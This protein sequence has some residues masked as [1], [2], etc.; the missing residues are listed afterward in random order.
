MSD[1]E[2]KMLE[3]PTSTESTIV[4]DNTSSAEELI[5]TIIS[6]NSENV[7]IE[8]IP[9]SEGKYRIVITNKPDSDEKDSVDTVD[10]DDLEKTTPDSDSNFDKKI[11]KPDSTESTDS[12]E[13]TKELEPDPLEGKDYVIQ[14]DEKWCEIHSK[15]KSVKNK[16]K[17]AKSFAESKGIPFIALGADPKTAIEEFEKEKIKKESES[18]IVKQP[19]QSYM[20]LSP[21]DTDPKKYIEFPFLVYDLPLE[22]EDAPPVANDRY[23]I[24][25]DGMGGAGRTRVVV[26]GEVRKMAYL[27][28]RQIIQ[29]ADKYMDENYGRILSESLD[30]ISY[31]LGR[32]ILDGLE[33]FAEGNSIT[34]N[35]T[36][37]M[38]KFLPS[39]FVSIVYKEQED[40]ID[41]IVFWAGDSRA[42]YISPED[43]LHPLS[44]DDAAVDYDD[45]GSIYSQSEISNVPCLDVPFHINYRRYLLKKPCALFVC[46]DG[47]SQYA[48]SP[49]D[50]EAMFIPTS[51]DFD[52]CE[53]IYNFAFT[54][55]HD[56]RTF[57]GKVYGVSNFVEFSELMRDRGESVLK[58]TRDI[59]EC[60]KEYAEKSR[61]Y[62]DL[63]KQPSTPENKPL[64]KQAYK[65]YGEMDAIFKKM[66]NDYWSEYKP[67]YESIKP[68]AEGA[69][70][71][72][73]CND[74]DKSIEDSNETSK[75]D[76]VSMTV[77][78]SSTEEG[79][80]SPSPI[81]VKTPEEAERDPPIDYDHKESFVEPPTDQKEYDLWIKTQYNSL[82]TSTSVL[83]VQEFQRIL[84]WRMHP[85]AFSC[86]EKYELFYDS[87]GMAAY[88][89]VVKKAY[90][91]DAERRKILST[92][93]E[94]FFYGVLSIPRVY[95]EDGYL[96]L[97]YN[98]LALG[99]YS[100]TR[101]V[102]FKTFFQIL[103][104]V[105]SYIERLH[106]YG[107]VHGG[108]SKGIEIVNIKGSWRPII[109]D[110]LFIHRLSDRPS[111]IPDIILDQGF[112][113]DIYCLGHWFKRINENQYVTR[114]IDS[115]D[116]LISDMISPDL[117]KRPDISAVL[118]RLNEL[119]KSL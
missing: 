13:D 2:E 70:P 15:G 84:G 106:N 46:S 101:P 69:S 43:G 86:N 115:L 29:S 16:T 27:A 37:K 63:N 73:S 93:N 114:R 89:M 116:P 18:A 105:S 117:S 23:L 119:M 61:I 24:A 6:S 26:N 33:Q 64:R 92:K 49:M 108:L 118:K 44:K 80:I 104:S 72:I 9:T 75:D 65:E 78:S 3:M 59:D 54:H 51:D 39:T 50:L 71:E 41:V 79:E 113:Y 38:Q 36:D 55:P 100:P 47:I 56:D 57:S 91:Y 35:K 98:S 45:M 17:V 85:F 25:C 48:N 103:F 34:F 28:S 10:E 62:A 32:C 22:G 30:S 90:P 97:T 31:E 99:G 96:I 20:E 14:I 8:L 4:V 110:H 7:S 58:M 21:I 112:K 88:I 12:P 53:S 52:L 76:D 11:E 109:R 1:E 82:R 102:D 42:Y 60:K 77:D 67:Q 87:S 107:F 68:I 83:S 81:E 95:L 5:K 40:A 19:E 111:D 66:C 94:D 74:F